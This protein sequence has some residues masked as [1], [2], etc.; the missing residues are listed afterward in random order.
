MNLANMAK[1]LKCAG[2]DD[3]ITVSAK[4]DDSKVMFVIESKGISI[5]P[6]SCDWTPLH[7]CKFYQFILFHFTFKRCFSS[8]KNLC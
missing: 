5:C 2:V 3:I 8:Q 1:M 6:V 4:D 7:A